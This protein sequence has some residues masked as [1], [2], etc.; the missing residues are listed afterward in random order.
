VTAAAGDSG[1]TDSQTDGAPHCDFPAASPHVLG[2]G[3]TTLHLAADGSIA[4][5]SVWNDG[6]AGGSTGGGVSDAFPVPAWQDGVGVPLRGGSATTGRGVPD[7]AAVA[8]PRTGYQVLVDGQA[9]VIGGTSAVAPLWAGLVCR[10]AQLAGRRFGLLSPALYA[11]ASA[12]AVPP[13][14][15]D[16]TAGSNGAYSAQPGW[17]ACT[18]LGVPSG[19]ALLE[20]LRAGAEAAV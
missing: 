19:S 14:F 4:S 16:I 3:G 8:D 13:G 7:V 20:R 10:L 11:G 5:E 2:C 1:S 9:G 17:D 12:G 15:R 18:G 6:A